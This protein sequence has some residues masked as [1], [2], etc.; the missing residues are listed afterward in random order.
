MVNFT[1]WRICPLVGFQLRK[2]DFITKTMPGK[3]LGQE[4]ALSVCG[5]IPS[6]AAA[7]KGFRSLQYIWIKGVF[8]GNYV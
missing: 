3:V 2:W 5:P 4:T 7:G 6:T 1:N 8:I